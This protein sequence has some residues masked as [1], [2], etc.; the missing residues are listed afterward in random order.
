MMIQVRT[1]PCPYCRRSSLVEVDGD[2]FEAWQNGM[3]VQ[4]AFPDKSADERELLM[5]GTHTECWDAMF[6]GGRMRLA[7]DDIHIDGV[8]DRDDTVEI[9][10]VDHGTKELGQTVYVDVN[11]VTLVRLCRIKKQVE[12]YRE[13]WER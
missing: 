11:G 1:R 13:E 3:K 7:K 12:F 8:A 4:D 9:R 6:Q 5:T 10:V 2:R